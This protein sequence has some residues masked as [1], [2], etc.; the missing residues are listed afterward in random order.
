VDE[1]GLDLHPV[2]MRLAS[3]TNEGMRQR[4]AQT[5]H[6][7][8]STSARRP[9]EHVAQVRGVQ[10]ADGAASVGELEAAEG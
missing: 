1:G 5:S 3:S 8:R 7:S 2:L 6:A 9:R 10:D 4:R